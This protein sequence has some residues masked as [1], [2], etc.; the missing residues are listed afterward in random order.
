MKFNI[1]NR[2]LKQVL[3]TTKPNEDWVWGVVVVETGLI[4][5]SYHL[6]MTLFTSF[7]VDADDLED[8]DATE[9]DKIATDPLPWLA[10][11]DHYPDS[12]TTIEQDRLK[13]RFSCKTESCCMDLID[14]LPVLWLHPDTVTGPKTKLKNPGYYRE[15]TP[16]RPCHVTVSEDGVL[17]V[18]NRQS[19]LGVKLEQPLIIY[20][21]WFKVLLELVEPYTPVTVAWG[22][23]ITVNLGEDKGCMYLVTIAK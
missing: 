4:F 3:A 23:L 10:I 21:P 19:N 18:G 1:S 16:D 2:L 6:S 8:I 14:P 11:L 9:D 15:I 5:R 7:V 20:G 17:T 22:E 13:V 12:F